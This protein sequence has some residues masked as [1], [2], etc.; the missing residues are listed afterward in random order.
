M[1]Y[2]L[3]PQRLLPV[4]NNPSIGSDLSVLS[5]YQ[6]GPQGVREKTPIYKTKRAQNKRIVYTDTSN[7]L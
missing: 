4:V 5:V 1:L 2:F 6:S 3:P 7:L